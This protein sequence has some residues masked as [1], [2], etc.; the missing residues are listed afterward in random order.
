MWVLS[1]SASK[2]FLFTSSYFISPSCAQLIHVLRFTGLKI[3]QVNVTPQGSVDVEDLKAKCEKYKDT[4]S[5]FM[6]CRDDDDDYDHDYDDYD[7]GA[8]CVSILD[9]IPVDVRSV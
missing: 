5:A 8:D 6:V 2:S 3:V 4:L 1:F 7:D 9:H